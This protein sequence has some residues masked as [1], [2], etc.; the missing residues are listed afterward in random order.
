MLWLLAYALVVALFG[1]FGKYIPGGLI[2]VSPGLVGATG[3]ITE[4]PLEPPPISPPVEP[5]PIS[6]PDEPPPIS[7]PDEPPL[8]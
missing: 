3:I 6:P 2:F 7:P 5:P 4:P 8:P 1:S